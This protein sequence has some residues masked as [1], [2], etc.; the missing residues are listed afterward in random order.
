MGLGAGLISVVT[1]KKLLGANY[2]FAAGP[3]VFL[4]SALESPTFN[5]NPSA[6]FGD[7]FI[8]PISLGWH[9]KR[10]DV[11]T[12][13]SIFLPTGRYEADADDNTGL[14]M[15]GHEVALGTTVFLTENKAFHAFPG[16]LVEGKNRVFALGPEVTIPLATKAKLFGFFTFR[17]EWETYARTSL[18]GNALAVLFTFLMKPMSLA[19]PK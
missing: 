10:A 4:N 16:L 7:I 3:L 11:T 17:Y 19:P 2:G 1:A 14:G 15:T 12:S 8:T 9:L 18:K 5:Q 6:G 13:Y